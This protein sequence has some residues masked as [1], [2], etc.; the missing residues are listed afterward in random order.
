M[1]INDVIY[2]LRIAESLARECDEY[3][4]MCD[5]DLEEIAD[6]IEN[7]IDNLESIIQNLGYVEDGIKEL[8]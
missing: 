8:I 7:C 2:D 5:N 3:Y 6:T 4:D 1:T